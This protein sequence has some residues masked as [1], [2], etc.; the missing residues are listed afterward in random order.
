MRRIDM[1]K[2]F[3]FILIC[4]L[5]IVFL[6]VH[7]LYIKG[8]NPGSAHDMEMVLR[9]ATAEESWD[10]F[11]SSRPLY[12]ITVKKHVYPVDYFL[13][14]DDNCFKEIFT[15]ENVADDYIAECREK[16]IN[17]IYDEKEL[18]RF[19]NMLETVIIPK[20]K[21]SIDEFLVPLL[22][23]WNT[24]LPSKLEIITRYGY[25]GE[26][27]MD[28]DGIAYLHF[29]MLQYPNDKEKIF[30]LFFHEFVHILIEKPIIQKYNVPQDLKERIVDLICYEF[31]K[32]PFNERFEDSFA[33]AYITPEVI[34]TDLP[35]AVK[36]MMSDYKALQQKQAQEK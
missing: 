17:Q 4:V 14:S 34:K 33:N 32:R 15:Q 6:L 25:G 35:G 36:K 20:L 1:K 26:Y 5:S 16:F 28:E 21:Q 27:W 29:K 11:M 24:K 9:P 18:H 22:P 19:D 12:N 31:I 2:T 7:H 3:L 13:P 23:S 30:S 10:V 8:G